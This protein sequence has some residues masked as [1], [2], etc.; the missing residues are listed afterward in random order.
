MPE[1][2]ETVEQGALITEPLSPPGAH[3]FVWNIANVQ[4]QSA[5]ICEYCGLVAFYGN[6]D[7]LSGGWRPEA[8]MPCPRNPVDKEKS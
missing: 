6:R 1:D 5:A 3:K 8:K 4:Y 7:L 2:L